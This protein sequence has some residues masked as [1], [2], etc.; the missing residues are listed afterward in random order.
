[1]TKRH[2]LN[3]LSS[4]YDPLGIISPTMV[5]GKRIYREACDEKVGWNSEVSTSTSKDWIKW[6]QQLR[7]VKS[8]AREIRKVKA[9]YLHLFADASF[10]ACSAVTIAV[11]EHSSGIVKGLLTSKS[12]IA[13]RNTS[14]PR[15]ELV[16]GQMA[17]N[18][19]TNLVAALRR[20]PIA[21]VTVWMDSL[22]ALFWIASPERSWKVFASNRTRKIAEI[23]EEIGISW[24]Y[25]Q[26]EVNLADLG[27]RG[28]SIDKMEKGPPSL[29][30]FTNFFQ[31]FGFV[32]FIYSK[33][34]TFRIYSYFYETF[35]F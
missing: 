25:C 34:C 29:S 14:I 24:K 22:V 11:I 5:E 31:N 20:W 23:T 17:A 26:S 6:R 1:M 10:T 30:H 27:S 4:I 32:C 8:L 19:S 9:I 15:L 21:S 18:L 3:E 13:K 33:Y 7:N 2:I 12:R 16:S 35:I 28:A